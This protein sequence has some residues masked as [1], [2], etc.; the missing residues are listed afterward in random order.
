MQSPTSNFGTLADQP[1]G[2]NPANSTKSTRLNPN[3][4][5]LFGLLVFIFALGASLFHKEKILCIVFAVGAA[6]F[7]L[8]GLTL[9]CRETGPA[10]ETETTP[11]PCWAQTLS[12]IV[13][14]D[15]IR[16]HLLMPGKAPVYAVFLCVASLSAVYIREQ[17]PESHTLFL[18]CTVTSAI[19][20]LVLFCLGSFRIDTLRHEMK[21]E[22]RKTNEMIMILM[23]EEQ[24]QIFRLSSLLWSSALSVVWRT[25]RRNRH[26]RIPMAALRCKLRLLN[27][28]TPPPPPNTKKASTL[29]RQRTCKQHVYARK[30]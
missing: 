11:L 8:I 26:C 14:E 18:L 23:T 6:T 15:F 21:E 12:K 2:A 17:H 5:P 27:I 24:K 20:G 19:I 7:G 25:K 4:S 13:H 30:L 10:K 22:F 9:C 28:A 29:S 3:E 1:A 16:A